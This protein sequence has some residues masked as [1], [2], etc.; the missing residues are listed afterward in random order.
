MNGLSN[1]Q[2]KTYVQTLGGS[3]VKRSVK[4]NPEAVK[5][6]NKVGNEVY[7][8]HYDTLAGS[9]I[10]IDVRTSEI[11][12]GTRVIKSERLEIEMLCGDESIILNLMANSSHAFN[13]YKR[14]EN[15][16]YMKPVTFQMWEYDNPFMAVKQDDK[17]IE[18]KYTKE[19]IPEW[20]KVELN[21]E[22]AWDKSEAL[23]FFRPKV[24]EVK[25][26]IALYGNTAK[27]PEPMEIGGG[28]DEND[29]P[30]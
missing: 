26:Q 25:K 28:D 11:E 5:R 29:L 3:F 30:F 13:F 24:K 1:S 10:D 8:L 9:I 4:E 23:N 6:I 12:V 17:L 18:A 22:V 27:R 14:M 15:I 21:G 2:R 20:K 19:Q 16:D 7:E